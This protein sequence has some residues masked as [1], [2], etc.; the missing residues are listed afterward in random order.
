MS[1]T[2][3]QNTPSACDCSPRLSTSAVSRTCRSLHPLARFPGPNLRALSQIPHALS[4]ANGTQARDVRELHRRY[5]DVVRIAP[6]QLSFITPSAWKDI[7]GQTA[8]KRFQKFGYFKVRPDAQPLLTANGEEHTRQRSAFAPGFSDRAIHAQENPLAAQIDRFIET[9]KQ[10]MAEDDT[11]DIGM[12]FRFLA[13]DIIGEF[14]LST[15]FSCVSNHAYH[16]WVALLV[17][18]FRAV[19]FVNIAN[20]FG[21]LAPLIMLFAPRKQLQGVKEHLRMSAETMH[22]R[23]S[24]SNDENQ[25]DLWSHV[26]RN[27]CH[28]S[29]SDAEMEVNAALLI[30]A[31]TEP[32][33]DVLC[34]AIYL[35]SKHPL[36][37]SKLVNELQDDLHEGEE[38]TISGVARLPFL[39]AVINETMR[40]YPPIPGGLRRQTPDG[41][42]SIS[43][44]FIP[45]KTVVSVF[46]LPAYT[47][48]TNFSLP[49]KFIPERWLK[50]SHMD[51][52]V[53]TLNDEHDAFQ[54]FGI[55][56]RNCIGKGLAYTEMK[57]ILARFVWNFTFHLVDEAFDIN[58]QRVYLFRER[59]PLRVQLGIR[60]KE[61]SL[62]V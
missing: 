20:S 62:H 33:S 47:L 50:E 55:G 6:N 2:A 48:P 15:D 21:A 53:G 42:A 13:F 10:I 22:T 23:L 36:A 19:S 54:P 51:R 43:G 27:Q 11:V 29:L 56:P 58:K 1:G 7:Y 14:A 9:L 3:M 38:F 41:G 60:R 18:W 32:L 45:E 34:G 52:P 8:T 59:P 16:P 35:L 12:W 49:D 28:R 17:E 46:Q 40:L 39:H 57:L 37:L 4:A 31:A 30:V 25:S 26:L 61:S 5:G 24:K 44:Y